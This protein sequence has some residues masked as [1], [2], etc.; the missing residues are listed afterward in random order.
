MKVY[1]CWWFTGLW[2]HPASRGRCSYQL[3]SLHLH[4]N[5]SVI[6]VAHKKGGNTKSWLRS[7]SVSTSETETVLIQEQCHQEW[8]GAVLSQWLDWHKKNQRRRKNVSQKQ[9]ET[10]EEHLCEPVWHDEAKS[11][12]SEGQLICWSSPVQK[13]DQ[14]SPEVGPVQSRSWISSVQMLD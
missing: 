5:V 9:R 4:R 12:D 10:S 2:K 11:F 8:W 3:T 7:F 6:S 1:R 13:L 14:S